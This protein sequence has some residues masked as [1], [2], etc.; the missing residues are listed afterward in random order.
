MRRIWSAQYTAHSPACSYH[1][2]IIGAV[3]VCG[4]DL[5]R[6]EA[7][8]F[9]CGGDNCLIWLAARV[10]RVSL[11]DRHGER[12]AGQA[13]STGQAP[14]ENVALSRVR[15]ARLLPV[16]R[17]RY[18]LPVL[19]LRAVRTPSQPG[20]SRFQLAGRDSGFLLRTPEA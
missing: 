13:A 9:V 17:V 20:P 5:A 7:T 15:H 16:L 8:A 6:Q 1:L 18:M 2:Y 12:P 19:Y 11:P 3:G 10:P 14:M 4:T